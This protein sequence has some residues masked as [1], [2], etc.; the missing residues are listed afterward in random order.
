MRCFNPFFSF[1][2]PFSNDRYFRWHMKTIREQIIELGLLDK[3][4]S[5]GLSEVTDEEL[6]K[7]SG[8][9]KQGMQVQ[10]MAASTA[11]SKEAMKDL[12]KPQTSQDAVDVEPGK[13]SVK[14]GN[15][16]HQLSI[17][18]EVE[19]ELIRGAVE[20]QKSLIREKK[21]SAVASLAMAALTGVTAVAIGVSLAAG[22]VNK[23]RKI[24]DI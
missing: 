24:I 21:Y 11:K 8:M 5:E 16:T 18:S 7:M 3:R 2:R 22:A 13:L 14:S 19:Q 23:T 20:Y 1:M 12:K 10:Q 9:L 4:A 15:Y 17:S 6:E